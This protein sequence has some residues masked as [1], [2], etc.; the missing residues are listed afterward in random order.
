MSQ[1]F[2]DLGHRLTSQ[3]EL[4]EQIFIRFHRITAVI[5]YGGM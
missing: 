4:Y 5:S 3:E 1:I 2:W